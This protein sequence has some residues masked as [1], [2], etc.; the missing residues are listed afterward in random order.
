MVAYI[1]SMFVR[2]STADIGHSWTGCGGGIQRY[3]LQ[4]G[5]IAG[6]IHGPRGLHYNRVPL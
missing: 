6:L 2:R 5:Y 3:I 4:G 1:V